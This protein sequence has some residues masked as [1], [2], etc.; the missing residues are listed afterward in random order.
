MDGSDCKE[1]DTMNGSDFKETDTM[2]GSDFKE[3]A[4]S[5]SPAHLPP[6]FE[7]TGV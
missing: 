1:T 6:S 7:T 5:P 4:M 2:N 3:T